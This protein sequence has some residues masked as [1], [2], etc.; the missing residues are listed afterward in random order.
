MRLS[1]YVLTVLGYLPQSL[2]D[3]GFC[4]V[5]GYLLRKRGLT[6]LVERY[7]A[8][9]VVKGF[10]QRPGVDF[11]EVYAPVS[12]KAGLRVLLSAITHRKMF[13]RQLAFL[14]VFWYLTSTCIVTSLKASECL[15]PDGSPL[16]CKLVKSLYGLKQA[17]RAWSQL[18]KKVLTAHGFVMSRA[19]PALYCRQDSSGGWTYVLTYVDDLII[20]LD[21]LALYRLLIKAMEAAGWEV[22]ELGVLVQFLS[23]DMQHTLDSDGRCVK[24][25]LS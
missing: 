5:D 24:I 1:P 21:D 23:L 15:R 11:S 18:V 19:E 9:F 10:L 7:K 6:G 13:V 16:V 2:P 14:M 17:P 20:A 3:N 8:R 4:L 22:K 25:N 12:H